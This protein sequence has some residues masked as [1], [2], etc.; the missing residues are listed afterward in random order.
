MS[1]KG[2]DWSP[3]STYTN[4][5]YKK[6]LKNQPKAASSSNTKNTVR[7]QHGGI[8]GGTSQPSEGPVTAQYGQKP[9]NNSYWQWKG[10][11][12]GTDY[13]LA[14]GST[15]RAVKG[16]VVKAAGPG[17]G[18]RGV[19]EPYGN[20]VLIDHGDGYDSL[21]AHLTNATVKPGQQ[22]KAGQQIA[23]SGQTGSGAKG[24]HLHF[25]V[26]KGN[27]PVDPK[28]FIN[29]TVGKA[30]DGGGIL[31]G[32]KKA[33]GGVART[34]G[35]AF[36]WLTG[37]D[38][39]DSKTSGFTKSG[40]G[41]SSHPIFS[42]SMAGVVGNKDTRT[43][44]PLGYGGDMGAPTGITGGS[45]SSGVVINMNV[46]V[47]GT[48]SQDARKFANDVKSMLEKDLRASKIGSY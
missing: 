37:D 39:D 19:G 43:A 30:S 24:P 5:A 44:S 4:G 48:S 20:V 32:I 46:T 9:K 14:K 33:L 11:H 18:I 47:H 29:G 41:A 1:N 22:V 3:W 10:Y 45:T 12:T 13:G 16:G 7:A 23:L 27:N 35:K 28:K 15:V 31:G 34:L 6:F 38:E 17:S 40:P 8:T 26:R 2:R 21:Y 36:N 42:V 25:E